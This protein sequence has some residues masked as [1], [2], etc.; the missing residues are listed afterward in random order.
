MSNINYTISKGFVKFDQFLGIVSHVGMV[1]H[2]QLGIGM[3][4]NDVIHQHS[5]DPIASFATVNAQSKHIVD[6]VWDDADASN[7]LTACTHNVHFTN[8]QNV[9]YIRRGGIF[10][11][12]FIIE[13]G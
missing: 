13:A 5:T 6:V 1:E 10:E 9:T 4:F 12:N 7:N 11:S 8:F 3:M 2:C